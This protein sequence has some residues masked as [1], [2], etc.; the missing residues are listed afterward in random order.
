[1]EDEVTNVVD[2]YF[3]AHKIK[4]D[5]LAKLLNSINIDNTLT[6]INIYINIESLLNQ[7]HKPFI[8]ESLS[9]MD[10]KELKNFHINLIANILNIIAHYRRF[11]NKHKLKTNIVLFANEYDKYTQSNNSVFIKNY[12]ERFIYNYTDNPSFSSINKVLS[13]TIPNV[14][15]IVNYIEDCYF[16]TT[17]RYE[18]SV[19][20]ILLCNESQ[21]DGQLN[22]LISRDMYDLQY[23]NRGFLVLYPKGEESCI[24]YKINLFDFISERYKID[25]KYK[26]PSYVFPF[27]L[28]V[29]GDKRR[30]I[31]GVK[32][33]G[34]KTVYKEVSKL[35]KSLGIDDSEVVPLE[36]LITSIRESKYRDYS[37]KEKIARNLVCTDV[38][39][40]CKMITNSQKMDTT[41]ELI[42]KF[43]PN[44]LNK[45][46]D[47]YFVRNPI[48]II[49]LEQFHLKDEGKMF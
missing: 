34:W 45:L 29:V 49:G 4:F 27:V 38:L 13:T 3:N 37:V 33:W 32:G 40:Q 12:R 41:K 6:K 39:R 26:L 25:E 47:N 21:L 17:A 43:E 5:N 14:K 46:N 1:M 16:L 23:V 9:V 30:N 36:S 7:I 24:I 10:K 2:C 35:F 20:P 42:N 48:D 22:I 44:A 8:E 15:T 19:I 11:F 28:S 18:S 31:E